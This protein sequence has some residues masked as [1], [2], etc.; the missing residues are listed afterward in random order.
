MLPDTPGKPLPLAGATFEERL[1]NAR[2][3]LDAQFVEIVKWHFNPE[4]G[5]PFWLEKAKTFDF[6]PLTDVK[7]FDDIRRFPIFEDD[8]LR[9][10][11]VR[12]WVPRAY[13]NRGVYVFETGGTTGLPKSRI[14]IDDFKID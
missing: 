7:S 9:G 4:T 2:K 3:Q 6:N 11:P 5:T 10:G 13:E 8:W 1:A 12:K 14:V